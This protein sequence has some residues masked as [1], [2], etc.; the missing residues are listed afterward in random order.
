MVHTITR[1]PLRDEVYSSLQYRND[2]DIVMQISGSEELILSSSVQ[3]YR[4]LLLSPRRR[5]W[6][7]RGRHT[8]KLNTI[9]Y[10]YVMSKTLSVR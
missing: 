7:G 4:K 5:C 9:K 10:F 1:P 2:L 3:K 8:L 6:C